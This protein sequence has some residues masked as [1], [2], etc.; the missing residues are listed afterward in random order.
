MSDDE[1]DYYDEDEYFYIDE[2]PVAE[3]VSL[4]ASF[5]LICILLHPLHAPT[6]LTSDDF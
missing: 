6:H 2:G 1:D 5:C 4:L 3:A